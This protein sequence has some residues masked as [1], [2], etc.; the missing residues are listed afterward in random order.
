LLVRR[1]KTYPGHA[2]IREKRMN[3]SGIVPFQCFKTPW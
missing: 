1:V 2:L 3:H